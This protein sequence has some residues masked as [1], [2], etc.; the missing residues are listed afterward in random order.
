MERDNKWLIIYYY[1]EEDI[2]YYGL[3]NATTYAC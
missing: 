3:V 1:R 2:K